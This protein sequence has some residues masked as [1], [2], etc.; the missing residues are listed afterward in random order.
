MQHV[1]V[2]G[3]LL[4][5]E[6][7]EALTG[8]T[9][10]MKDGILPDFRRFAISG[11][12]YPA[13]VFN[14]GSTV[15]GKILLNVDDRSLEILKFYEGD[16]YACI[17]ASINVE[18]KTTEALVF[19]WKETE[20]RLNGNWSENHFR[21]TLLETYISEVAPETRMEFEALRP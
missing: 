8:T 4:F 17:S 13:I 20:E 7:V 11:A 16:E 1:F 3:S 14:N 9:F 18:N 6:V 15:K 12:D 5:P 2:Y 10:P 21:E 19:V